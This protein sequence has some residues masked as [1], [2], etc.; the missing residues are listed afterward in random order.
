LMASFVKGLLLLIVME[1]G[2]SAVAG[3][4]RVMESGR[5]MFW[6][7]MFNIMRCGDSVDYEKSRCYVTF[8]KAKDGD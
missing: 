8:P 4:A 2:R 6:L 5:T 7:M 3:L 1:R